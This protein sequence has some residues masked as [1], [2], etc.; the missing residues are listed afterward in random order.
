MQDYQY[1][2]DL[3]KEVKTPAAVFLGTD[4]FLNSGIRLVNQSNYENIRQTV[5]VLREHDI[6]AVPCFSKE[7]VLPNKTVVTASGIQTPVLQADKILPAAQKIVDTFMELKRLD[8]E[9]Y[10]RV[11]NSF[12]PANFSICSSVGFEQM[13]EPAATSHPPVSQQIIPGE[14]NP[15]PSEYA[16][17][18]QKL[19]Y[20]FE[21]NMIQEALSSDKLIPTETLEQDNK[22]KLAYLYRGGSLG[23]QPYLILSSREGKTLSYATPDI[24]TAMMYSGCSSL[25]GCSLEAF[26][27]KNN[28]AVPFGFVYEFEAA[29]DTYLYSDWS[30]EQGMKSRVG[31]SSNQIKMNDWKEQNLETAV[32]SQKNKLHNVYL[33]LKKNG[34]DVLFPIPQNDHRWQQFLQLY[35]TSDPALRGYMIERRNNVLAEKKVYSSLNSNKKWGLFS[36]KLKPFDWDGINKDE[37]ISS[38]NQTIENLRGDAFLTDKSSKKVWT[39]EDL[40]I[41]KQNVQKQLDFMQQRK[42]QAEYPD[43]KDNS[44]KVSTIHMPHS[45]VKDGG[46]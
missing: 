37:A 19:G 25:Y 28:N 3:L 7:A 8:L 12:I 15:N 43:V 11:T 16:E 46:R 23:D 41:L 44:S 35:R 10:G 31:K 5:D 22:D 6:D 27:E 32:S 24:D 17:L 1:L 39:A 4:R 30:I 29:K 33:H 13:A 14:Y 9:K 21:Y 42:N 34:K 36:K 2:F 20:E 38:A 18:R 45:V 40:N 26:S